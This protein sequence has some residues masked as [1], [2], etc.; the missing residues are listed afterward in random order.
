MKGE[1]MKLLTL[2]LALTLTGCMHLHRTS[3]VKAKGKDIKTKLGTIKGADY[4]SHTDLCLGKH[5]K[6]KT[7]TK[8]K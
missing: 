8:E 3:D 7:Q 1:T 6:C 5:P 4:K 2:I